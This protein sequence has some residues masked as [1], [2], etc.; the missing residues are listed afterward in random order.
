M[1][2]IVV[3]LLPLPVLIKLEIK[4]GKK[5]GLIS[6]F[7][8]GL[9]TTL[10][11]IMRYTQIERI[12]KNGDSTMLVLWGTIEFN[13]GVSIFV[14]SMK[15]N[16]QAFQN[17]VSSLPF[18]APVFIRTAKKYR[19]KHSDNYVTPSGRSRG[20][21]SEHYRLRDMSH[22]KDTAVFV[23]AANKSRSGSEEN[24]LGPS[25]ITKHMTYSVRVDEDGGKSSSGNSAISREAHP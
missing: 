19:S 16:T 11:S 14:L 6:I 3:A 2:D 25:G 22:G 24:I 23:S 4:L 9:F 8:L 18:L 17:M 20:P 21:K 12:T 13:V 1:S 7:I 15:Q 5:L 10:C